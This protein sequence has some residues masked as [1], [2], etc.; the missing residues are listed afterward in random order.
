[1]ALSL[2]RSGKNIPKHAGERVA[3]QGIYASID[4]RRLYKPPPQYA[5]HV[6]IRLDDG[7]TVLLEPSWHP[8]ARRSNAEREAH[9]GRLVVAI[10][11]LHDEAP[12]APDGTAS[13]RMPCLSEID[14]IELVP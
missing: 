7:E 14:S 8:D 13:V 10:G 9:E 2:I 6:A 1:M 3:V 11:I 4:L 5:G 12:D